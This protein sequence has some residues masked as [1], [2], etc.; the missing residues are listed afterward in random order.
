MRLL[1]VTQA[2][3][4]NEPVLGF[5]CG[6]LT[7]F[8][9]H[10]ERIEVIC[11]FEGEHSLP[12]NVHVHS[13]G[14]EKRPYGRVAYAARF[15]S[16]AWRLRRDYDTVLV[17][18]NPEYVILGGALWR[19]AGKKVALWYN[20][21]A[22]GARFALAAALANKIFYTSP[23]AAPAHRVKAV[24]MPAGIDTELFKPTGAKRE[25]ARIYV[26]GRITPSKH[27]ETILEALRA[28]RAR[29]PV[30]LVL[31][32]PEEPRYAKMLRQK[33]ADLVASGAVSFAGSVPNADTPALFSA[34]GVS[35]NLAASGHFDKSVLEAMACETP[36]IVS[37]KA[38]EGLIP[39]RLTVPENNPTA[40]A[41]K[42]AEI[43]TLPGPE[44]RSL[45][46]SL[47]TAVAETHSLPKLASALASA[48]Y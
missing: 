23:Y 13:L 39:A 44:Y 26:Q 6:W 12:Q 22:G 15:L 18:M 19:A 46:T 43:I 36:V 33:F 8:A 47:R 10:F 16:L 1:I 45:G 9:K 25:H 21:P 37:G 3:D 38:F 20:H 4:E 30:I 11:L 14:K 7:E 42:L 34:A 29:T 48:L 2:V 17:H 28:L 5:F 24:R 40:L 41:E 31:A 35:V 27:T 32:G